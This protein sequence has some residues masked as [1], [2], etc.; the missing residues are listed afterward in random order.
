[1]IL[2][3]CRNLLLAVPFLMMSAADASF[4]SDITS[5]NLAVA[6]ITNF[7]ES[8]TAPGTGLTNTGTISF[9]LEVLKLH[10]PVNFNLTLGA[11]A[12]GLSG[13]S[14]IT[15]N[16]LVTINV[17]NSLTPAN[18]GQDYLNGFDLVNSGSPTGVSTASLDFDLAPTSNVFAV[19]Y[20]GGANIPSGYR[21]GGLNGGG[22]AIYNTGGGPGGVAQVTFGYVLVG[23]NAGSANLSFTANPEPATLL[24]GSLALIPAGMV[25]RR[26]RK[27]A[28]ELAEAA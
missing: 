15:S 28:Q 10:T 19:Q 25:A 11:L 7:S 8:H 27:A 4:V 2:K 14:S 21:F 12:G 13:T 26:R 5:S 18:G 22:G 23:R 17:K 16:Y 1:M 24:L 9:D 6:K 20:A 3:V